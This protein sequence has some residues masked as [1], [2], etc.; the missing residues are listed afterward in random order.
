LPSLHATLVERVFAAG[1]S[2]VVG[3][4]ADPREFTEMIRAAIEGKTVLPC[5]LI[6]QLMGEAEG[7]SALSLKERHW[8]KELAEGCTVCDLAHRWAYSERQ[9]Y[10]RLRAVYG[11]LGARSK[12]QAL[13]RAERAGLLDG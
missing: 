11:R 7:A 13:L 1:A 8:L 2:A 5:E 3:C 6:R 9:M 10:R 12:T 4:C